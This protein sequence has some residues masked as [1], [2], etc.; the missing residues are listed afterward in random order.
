MVIERIADYERRF[1]GLSLANLP[2]AAGDALIR[3]L[4]V[5]DNPYRE[6]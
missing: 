4:V 5:V 2:D 6:P 3:A 1:G